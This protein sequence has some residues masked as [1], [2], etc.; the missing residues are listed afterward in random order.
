MAASAIPDDA[1]VLIVGAMKAGTTTL[2]SLLAQHPA[3]CPGVVK[4]PEFFSE[5]Q[6]HGYRVDAYQDLWPD[7]DPGRHRYA[8]E[9]SAGYAKWPAEQG[10]ADRIKAAGISP[11]IL[12]V[13]RDPVARIESH[14]QY[15]EA[16]DGVRRGGTDPYFIDLCRYATQIEPF[17][18][19]FGPERVH[20]LTFDDLTAA[21]ERTV[22]VIQD[23][24]GLERVPVELKSAR[25]RTADLRTSRLRRLVTRVRWLQRSVRLTPAWL[26][27][28]VER[29]LVKV[30]PAKTPPRT[31][32]TDAQIAEV[33]AEL[34]DE[35]RLLRD[36]FDIDVR[37][38]GFA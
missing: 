27:A 22:A 1:Y 6:R 4:E 16:K 38:W 14:I 37:P 10:V 15:M 23:F 33:R 28:G 11:K 7:F 20:V 31:R 9:A 24:L 35:M 25:N 5:N 32:L 8:L 26:R 36:R 19:A 21:P 34:A 30:L 18:A 13:V 2:H 17:E 3:I 12:Y 29:V